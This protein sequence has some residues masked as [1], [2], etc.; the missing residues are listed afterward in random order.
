MR[1]RSLPPSIFMRAAGRPSRACGSIAWTLARSSLISRTARATQVDITLYASAS[2]SVS[3]KSSA[4]ER[5][6]EGSSSRSIVGSC[7]MPITSHR[8]RLSP[9]ES[10]ASEVVTACRFGRFRNAARRGEALNHRPSGQAQPRYRRSLNFFEDRLFCRGCKL[11]M[12]GLRIR[13]ASETVSNER[14]AVRD[15][16]VDIECAGAT[17]Q[18]P[19]YFLLNA[20]VEALEWRNE[21]NLIR[22]GAGFRSPFS[23]AQTAHLNASRLVLPLLLPLLFLFCSNR[24]RAM[25]PARRQAS[26][27]A[28]SLPNGPRGTTLSGFTVAGGMPV[29]S[30]PPASSEA[31]TAPQVSAPLRPWHPQRRDICHEFLLVIEA[32]QVE[33]QAIVLD[34]ADNRRRQAAQRCTEIRE[35][36]P[37]AAFCDGPDREPGAWHGLAGQR[38]RPDLAL[39]FHSDDREAFPEP[40]LHRR[41]Q[42]ACQRRDVGCRARQ[43]A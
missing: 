25:L 38:A 7:V 27:G 1:S 31:R 30:I 37:G 12:E 6:V 3:M 18:K 35:H 2:R 16:P 32:S 41:P 29:R 43:Q 4:C 20:V 36:A 23:T 11:S 42:P 33:N 24:S 15:L 8:R 10:A 28:S 26:H 17:L 39:A 34:A 19:D 9:G 40:F 14:I 22:I 21:I 5:T 13:Q